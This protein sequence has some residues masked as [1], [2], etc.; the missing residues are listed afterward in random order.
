M[1]FERKVE[2]EIRV[3]MFEGDQAVENGRQ[4]VQTIF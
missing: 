3:E 1:I 2:L 4:W